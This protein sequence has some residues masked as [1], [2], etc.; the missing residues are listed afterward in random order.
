MQT[1]K[2][3]TF[4]FITPRIIGQRQLFHQRGQAKPA[5]AALVL[6][7]SVLL[8]G[9]TVN[10]SDLQRD[11]FMRDM[12]SLQN[13]VDQPHKMGQS[14]DVGN[15][16]WKIS[17]AHAALSLRLGSKMVKARGKFVVIDFTF[18]NTTDQ[19]QH[20]TAAMLQIEDGQLATYKSNAEATAL[21]AAWQK[22]PNFLKDTFQ[23]NKAVACSLVFDLPVDTS[24]L[25]LEFQSF[26]TQD[27][28]PD[29]M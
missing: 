27:N 13:Q 21:L 28:T 18:T 6:A 9:C 14:F 23:P 17:A 2:R 16:R 5:L 11:P 8:I 22:T 24:G 20:P 7:L 25:T 3:I 4:R 1:G 26:P 29:G 19:P 12:M 10:Q 15:T